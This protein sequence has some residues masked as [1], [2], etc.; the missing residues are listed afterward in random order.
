MAV[1]FQGSHNA[2]ATHGVARKLAEL[3]RQGHHH[4][5]VGDT[6]LACYRM[7]TNTTA[8]LKWFLLA[9]ATACS[10]GCLTSSAVRGFDPKVTPEEF[11]TVVK[12]MRQSTRIQYTVT[13]RR[14]PALWEEWPRYGELELPEDLVSSCSSIVTFSS[15]GSGS[16]DCVELPVGHA[17]APSLEPPAGALCKLPATAA[18]ECSVILLRTAS[19][20]GEPPVAAYRSDGSRLTVVS[21][22]TSNR[23]L[24]LVGSPFLDIVLAVA[25]VYSGV[26][27]ALSA[28]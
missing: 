4:R 25:V 28:L 8:V 1:N 3:E 15:V 21:K 27:T 22:N 18:P 5:C 13:S 11:V 12:P 10:G 9:A 7:R 19:P 16:G 2:V 23:W 14:Q 6:P 24:R 20:T 17:V 26:A